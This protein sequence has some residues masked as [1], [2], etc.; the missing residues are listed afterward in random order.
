MLGIA[1]C[2]GM[3]PDGNSDQARLRVI[4]A[5]PD[6]P[7]VDVCANGQAAFTG[8][9]FPS[10]TA[11]ADLDPGVYAVRVTAAG[12]GCNSAGVIDANLTLSR[13]QEISV[14][15]VDILDQIEPLVLIDDNT[16]PASGEAKVRFV[17]A[18]PDA[19]T[20]DITLADG[21]TLFDNIA[22]KEASAYLEVAAGM[23]DLQV[24]D[25]TGAVVV[26]ELDDVELAAGKIY[27][28]FAVGLLEGSPALDALVSVDN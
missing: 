6:A 7:E 14:V 21:T 1:G 9:A 4:H 5:S 24:R 22:F 19:P 27:T 3:V 16:P 20:V 15:A 26:L 10:V 28:V 25:E 23:Y 8:A 12:A 11:Y 18:S 2:P 13:G 17:H